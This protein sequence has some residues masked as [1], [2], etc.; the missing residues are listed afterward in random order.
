MQFLLYFFMP[1]TSSQDI[2][3]IVL[4][5]CVLWFTVFL[6][7][8][9]YQ[10][11]RVLRNANRIIEGLT[12]KLELISEAVDFIRKKVDGL[13][14]NMGIVSSLASGL[15]ERFVVG[16]L[17]KKFEERISEEP[18]KKKSTRKK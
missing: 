17:A 4:S 9:L 14:N 16:K 11:A 1:V 8:L 3:Y 7:W 10:A 6:C 18:K 13:S 2:L 5:L 15:M 12:N